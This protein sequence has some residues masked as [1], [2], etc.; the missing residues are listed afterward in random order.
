MLNVDY[1]KPYGYYTLTQKRGDEVKKFKITLC[2]ANAMWAEMY[3]Y[4]DEKT[5]E[6]MAQLY[7]FYAD[8]KHVSK[9]LSGGGNT[10]ADDFVFKAKEISDNSE[11]WKSIKVLAKYG[12][13]I[14]IK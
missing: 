2:K 10:E 8:A 5:G 3:F 7:S 13:K 4:K 12:K 6:D 1:K 9:H 11:I 14:T